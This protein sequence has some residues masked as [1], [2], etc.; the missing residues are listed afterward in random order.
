MTD[1][2]ERVVQLKFDSE[3]FE[4]KTKSTFSVLD[5]LHEKLSFKNRD[6]ESAKVM[7]DIADNVQ[8]VADKAYT[9]VDRMVD[10]IRDD[11][12]NKLVRFLRENTIGQL[13]SG[14]TKYADMTTSVATLK[15]QGYAMEQITDQLERLNYFTDETSFAF[16]SMVG[17]IGKFT[18]SGQKLEDATTAMMG[19]ASWAALSGKNA[20]EASRAMYQLSQALGA[21]YMR[22]EDWK[23]IQN[24]NMDT[25]EFR[26][27]AIEAGLALGTL[28]EIGKEVYTTTV[29][30]K[31]GK[32]AWNV[33]QF[34][35]NLTEGKWFTAD[36]MM[37]VYSKYSEAIDDIREKYIE[38]DEEIPTAQIL[39][40]VKENNKKIIDKFKNTSMDSKDLDKMLLRWKGVAKLADQVAEDYEDMDESA[41]KLATK[42]LTEKFTE[43]Q[44][45]YAK[46]F[47]GTVDDAEAALEDWKEYTSQFGLKAFAAGQ[48]AKTFI[49][50]IESAKDAASTVW[51][52]IYQDI[53]GDYDEAKEIWTDLANSLYDIF[54]GRLW[55][56]KGVFDYWRHGERDDDEALLEEY[57]KEYER[58]QKNRTTREENERFKKLPKLIKD[59]DDK[60]YHYEDK[61]KE[62]LANM[63]EEYK[64]LSQNRVGREQEERFKELP[65][66]IEE[67]ET[68]ITNGVYKSAYRDGRKILMQGI[69]ALGSSFK[70]VITDFREAWDKLTP[71]NA[72]GKALL[73]F[74]ERFR[75]TMF[76]LYTFMKELK[77]TDF[78]K[79]IA[80]GIKNL[81]APFAAV[82]KILI[83]IISL[84]FPAKKTAKETLVAISESFKNLTAKLVP[85]KE[86]ISKVARVLRGIVAI[87]KLIAKAVLG[88]YHTVL[89]PI[90]K[91]IWDFFTAIIG[92]ILEGIAKVGDWFYAL[93]ET[94]DELEAMAIVGETI[95][96]IFGGIFDVIKGI[97]SFI[98]GIISPAVMWILNL[99]KEL[100]LKVKGLFG[101]GEE[102]KG[103]FDNMKEGLGG[104][105]ERAKTAW[106][107]SKGLSDVWNKYKGGEGLPNFISMVGEM[108]TVFIEKIGKTISAIFG[109]DQAVANSK[110]S[111]AME[112]IKNVFVEVGTVVKW[113]WTNLLKPTITLIFEA[114]SG[115]LNEII[116][117]LKSGDIMKVLDIIKKFFST[118]GSIQLVKL[119]KALGKLFGSRGLL[120]VFKQLAGT[121][122]SASK[123]LKAAAFNQRMSGLIKF[124]I[125]LAILVGLL[126]ALTFLPLEN[127]QRLGELMKQ[128]AIAVGVMTGAMALL[129][130]VADKS[131]FGLVALSMSV[132]SLVTATLL[133]IWGAKKISEA[134]QTA[135]G[136]ESIKTIKGFITTWGPLISIIFSVLTVMKIAGKLGR[137]GG[138]ADFAIGIASIALACVG[139]V[140]ALEKINT[141]KKENLWETIQSILMLAGILLTL[142]L[143]VRIVTGAMQ[144]T[145][146]MKKGSGIQIL[147]ATVGMVLVTAFV[148]MPLLEEMVRK[149]DQ[150]PEYAIAVAL[151]A[152]T[153]LSISG[154]LRLIMGGK[155]T[156]GVLRSL[157]AVYSFYATIRIIEKYVL[158]MLE[159]LKDLDASRYLGG[160]A[161]LGIIL[162]SVAGALRLIM[163]GI[164]TIIQAI[165]TINWKSWLAIILPVGAIVAVVIWLSNMFASAGTE[166]SLAAILAPLGIVVAICVSFGLFAKSLA[167]T[168]TG[169]NVKFMEEMIKLI[170]AFTL[171]LT[172][173]G[174]S[175]VGMLTAVGL[176]FDNKE[177]YAIATMITSA[178]SL[179]AIIITVSV[180][181]SKMVKN[182]VETTKGMDEKSIDQMLK[183][184][185]TIFNIILVISGSMTAIVVA[186]AF[187]DNPLTMLAPLLGM[188]FGIGIIFSAIG[189]TV[190]TITKSF[191]DLHKELSSSYWNK[192]EYIEKVF[193]MISS[194]FKTFM[195]GISIII[196][197]IAVSTIGIGISYS[198]P[199]ASLAPILGMAGAVAIILG[200][201]LK[202]SK[203]I[204][205][206]FKSFTQSSGDAFARQMFEITS[207]I[208]TFMVCLA[209]IVG[210]IGAIGIGT[211]VA[212]G[213]SNAWQSFVPILSMTA[214]V[215]G[216][217]WAMSNTFK[218]IIEIIN[219]PEF[220][221]EVLKRFSI[222]MVAFTLVLVAT[223][224]AITV[225]MME[226]SN[227]NWKSNVANAIIVVGMSFVLLSTLGHLC[228]EMIDSVK[229][230]VWT[231][232]QLGAFAVAMAGIIL[233][234][235]VMA[236]FVSELQSDK[237]IEL[238]TGI[239]IALSLGAVIISLGIAISNII[240]SIKLFSAKPGN[241]GTLAVA[242][243]G[244]LLVVMAAEPLIRSMHSLAGV[245][246]ETVLSAM[247]GLSIFMIA[248]GAALK[249][250][251]AL[252][253]DSLSGILAFFGTLAAVAIL[254]PR[255]AE[256][257]STFNNVEW[258]A[259]WKGIVSIMLP[260]LGLVAAITLISGLGTTFMSASITIAV[261]VI[262][263]SAAIM[264]LTAALNGLKEFFGWGD[265]IVETGK[266]IDQGLATGIDKN[267]R[268]VKKSITNLAQNDT[269]DAYN[270]EVKVNSPSKEFIKS[271]KYIDQGLAKGIR[272][273]DRIVDKAAEG[274]GIMTNEGFQESLGISSPSK[275][276]YENGRFVVRGFL[277]GVQDEYNKNKGVGTAIGDG[278]SESL[279]ESLGG[280]S[281]QFKGIWDIDEDSDIAKFMANGLDINVSGW[282]DS[283]K[284]ELFG[285]STSEKTRSEINKVLDQSAQDAIR[286]YEGQ[287][288]AQQDILDEQYEAVK[289]E[290]IAEDKILGQKDH[291]DT[292]TKEIQR[293]LSKSAYKTA[294][295]ASD[296]VKKYWKAEETIKAVDGKIDKIYTENGKKIKTENDSLFG[297]IKGF[298]STG[299]TD[300]V[301][302]LVTDPDVKT[303]INGAL[304]SIGDFFTKWFSGDTA[305]GTGF[306]EAISAGLNDPNVQAAFGSF[307]VTSWFTDES[308]NSKLT[309]EAQG[310]GNT[311]GT[312]M[313]TALNTAFSSWLS[314]HSLL[315]SLYQLSE[316]LFGTGA[317]A[318]EKAGNASRRTTLA[319]AW[320]AHEHVM[321]QT[322]EEALK[323][324]DDTKIEALNNIIKDLEIEGISDIGDI[325]KLSDV[326][327]A[328]LIKYGKNTIN[329]QLSKGLPLINPLTGVKGDKD[330][331]FKTSV[332]I[333]N[334][335]PKQENKENKKLDFNKIKEGKYDL[336]DNENIKIEVPVKVLTHDKS[337]NPYSSEKVNWD[338]FV[339][340]TTKVANKIGDDFYDDGENIGKMF[341]L[342]LEQGWWNVDSEGKLTVIT[343]EFTTTM[344]NLIKARLKIA[345]PSK[346]AIQIMKFFMQ[347]MA[348]GIDNNT[349]NVLNSIDDATKLMTNETMGTLYSTFGDIDNLEANPSVVPIIDDYSFNRKIADFQTKTNSIN[350]RVNAA[351][352]S[353]SYQFK[354]YDSKF[355]ML[356]QRVNAMSDMLY[357]ALMG[358]QNKEVIINNTVTMEPNVSNLF[359]AFIDENKMRNQR[360]PGS[361]LV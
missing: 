125:A 100:A 162:L 196:G 357:G 183:Y 91:P 122:K 85:T 205:N 291:E 312:S 13:A 9:I 75:A 326:G 46:F 242:L 40:E 120:K 76:R 184:I 325:Y 3:D 15:A 201:M 139:L 267:S 347:G 333:N 272:K 175:I 47:G 117:A 134:M 206:V 324:W 190:K 90:L 29:G 169:H 276:F 63:K 281:E 157:A 39:K 132:L 27:N 292:L 45:E 86:F 223:M 197:L 128:G 5:K 70:M 153:I 360:V 193:G 198:N 236:G 327:F 66:L 319:V 280:I 7:N 111:S 268:V 129:S 123:Y 167:K 136:Q 194:L 341:V 173:I 56:I 89:V 6:T 240:N 254:A 238:E 334:I 317:E 271:G 342:G 215:I 159:S 11:I 141:I 103:F 237:F 84:F 67:L 1:I 275:V 80:I 309:G 20:G 148:V 318:K 299:L 127:L 54:V 121:L 300:A 273:Y 176:L 22:K 213:G 21:G 248:I 109:L 343:Q 222:V 186:G 32:Q 302:N 16:T 294:D 78:Y 168:M 210:L 108:L 262:A 246:W 37:E 95:K 106:K 164:A 114:V 150:F 191:V 44:K 227:A 113:I 98:W 256:A 218:T 266:S 143:A 79:N 216:V 133:F 297:K 42:N 287:K 221:S 135:F 322:W 185:K 92:T 96:K 244:M 295:D 232:T 192:P 19:I 147:I 30:D 329:E 163:G 71:D 24:L 200:M 38:N 338:K 77:E 25:K 137:G 211:A 166:I 119:W 305:D 188:A 331:Y 250:I 124:N 118:I 279:G 252:P 69:Y 55:D 217:L 18:A 35:E 284:D 161:A 50:A 99:V 36:V 126:T 330:D 269:I 73:N 307:D 255:I 10:K 171:M 165:S 60:L 207:F 182:F 310:I 348:L 265:E 219:R 226:L 178:I 361:G 335:K 61:A 151:F 145:F 146:K 323:Y 345:S 340:L 12:A 306:P 172:L 17:E 8:K 233:A 144:G 4:K 72:G 355:D 351:A 245:N 112:E 104:I 277:N 93:D 43:Y 102:G 58:L 105:A 286:T 199:L 258:D 52:G 274:L 241:I 14:W 336:T 301:D 212:Y 154:S 352:S 142:A 278:I 290:V 243:V 160:I 65:K 101:G 251:S 180:A 94:T 320:K 247:G 288:K 230:F 285:T 82:R 316:E 181:F 189:K 149:K 224:A 289:Q 356:A 214:A 359:D 179:I 138:L 346:V 314:Q 354:D 62:R 332:D 220:N 26:E 209:V 353:F 140:I 350:T 51:T 116:D 282:A 107:N 177:G 88:F 225:S 34:A 130:I 115:A 97:G 303:K 298:M 253:I 59:L 339:S 110:A 293:R 321:D 195:T 344:I 296:A 311:I 231:N 328:K 57:K 49:E 170:K 249:M 31:A 283:I 315:Y 257:F 259:I 208:K 228:N 308:G 229:S 87:I 158:P 304:G 41:K 261:G 2:D 239:S 64:L 203:D 23:S 33:Q 260:L 83:G 152:A 263:I 270:D 174:L 204:L 74:S 349:Q 235:G 264:V 313:A 156:G 337:N 53:F 68:D 28:K 202:Y 155:K 131:K 358:I 187:Y 81:L 48:E 234:I